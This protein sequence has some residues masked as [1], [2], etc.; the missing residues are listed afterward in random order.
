ML[1]LSNFRD[2]YDYMIGVTGVDEKVIFH[3]K[4]LIKTEF[5]IK[6]K[7]NLNSR[8]NITEDCDYFILSICGK[9][10][11]IKSNK[12][13]FSLTKWSDFHL[14]TKKDLLN[15]KV[16]VEIE[17]I[18]SIRQYYKQKKSKEERIKHLLSKIHGVYD[19]GLVNISKKINAPIFV[20]ISTGLNTRLHERSPKL[21]DIRGVS[22]LLDSKQLFNDVSFFI[23][24]TL[25][26]CNPPIVKISNKDK[27]IKG[28]F[29]LVTSF[30][31]GKS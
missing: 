15:N 22:T 14:I 21:V 12:P 20:V 16:L 26:D 10:Y 24:N 27:I 8:S 17:S 5:P 25:N 29:D 9:F 31:K 11:L 30:R 13:R 28:G 6:I 1:L 4:K 18:A 23:A 19:K 2:Y 3:R 7:L